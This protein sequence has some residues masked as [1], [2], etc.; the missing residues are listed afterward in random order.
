MSRFYKAQ[1]PVLGTDFMFDMPWDEV[2]KTMDA[3]QQ[4]YDTTL[5]TT[6]LLNNQLN[7]NHLSTDFDKQAVTDAQKYYGDRITEITNQLM[8]D[9]SARV[10]GQ[11]I[12]LTNELTKD[13]STGTLSKVKGRY[14]NYQAWAKQ[15]EK[16]RTDNPNVYNR[17]YSKGM[18]ALQAGY[19]SQGHNT[20]WGEENIMEDIDWTEDVKDIIKTMEPEMRANSYAKVGG[21][22]VYKGKS[23]E[24]ALS[25]TRI[26]KAV[27]NKIKAD[28]RF[29]SY[30]QQRG[31]YGLSGY[32][33]A[34]G[35][36]I[37]MFAQDATGNIV[38]NDQSAF[39]APLRHAGAFAY[40]QQ[41]SE[42]DMDVNQYAMEGVQQAGRVQLA[43][44]NS[45][46][47]MREAEQADRLIR[48]REDGGYG[49]S[50]GNSG[51]GVTTLFNKT[52]NFTGPG[53]A[54]LVG[55]EIINDNKAMLATFGVTPNYNKGVVESAST[56]T[57]RGL[58]AMRGTLKNLTPGTP[59]HTLLKLNID[60]LA[61]TKSNFDKGEYT[62]GVQSLYRSLAQGGTRAK[63]IPKAMQQIEES[64]TKAV[65]DLTFLK[66][67][68]GNAKVTV[69]DSGG[70]RMTSIQKR[71]NGFNP[72]SL[73]I[74]MYNGKAME[75][76]KYGEIDIQNNAG[77]LTSIQQKQPVIKVPITN[78]ND[79]NF[80][81][82]NTIG[83]VFTVP[84]GTEG[85]YAVIEYDMPLEHVGWDSSNTR[86]L[87]GSTTS[88][89][90]GTEN[91][92]DAGID[93]FRT[94]TG[95]NN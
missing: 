4:D 54:K 9:P 59:A 7:V 51:G 95:Q 69:Y 86:N 82:Q 30:A 50:G 34:S 20:T 55:A 57:T 64:A 2:D 31:G 84:V 47:R 6:A 70:N 27:E 39:A 17:A 28:P 22:W 74:P 48:A 15:N 11:L 79:K 35:N 77:N 94:I 89:T 32:T 81:K 68:P 93:G 85:Q 88:N 83:T 14:D 36:L 21:Q 1:V 10:K 42:Q 76:L 60:S 18:K 33:D 78:G 45:A 5:A 65:S 24:K 61:N 52:S 40:T 71:M 37:P 66:A 92:L 12:G 3:R 58:A 73:P 25:Q 53:Q 67:S 8:Q 75:G 44:L 16:M 90:F 43:N 72:N 23:S 41:E 49:G 29:A 80:V 56:F 38:I 87:G 91:M 26:M 13:L 62:A 19:D 63:D 46:N